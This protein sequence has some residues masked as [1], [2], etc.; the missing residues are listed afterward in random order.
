[1]SLNLN[2]YFIHIY[3]PHPATVEVAEAEPPVDGYGPLVFACGPPVDLYAG[4]AV[5]LQP[6]C[7]NQGALGHQADVQ[8]P[9]ALSQVSA[10]LVSAHILPGGM[11]FPPPIHCKLIHIRVPYLIKN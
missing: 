10:W 9:Q 1:M 5:L 3:S 8:T 7:H 6:A 11:H 4:A 2:S